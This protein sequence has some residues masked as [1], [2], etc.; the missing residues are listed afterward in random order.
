MRSLQKILSFASA[1]LLMIGTASAQS[2][3]KREIIADGKV[4]IEVIAEG[5]GPLGCHRRLDAKTPMII[6]GIGIR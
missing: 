4:R 1:L 3:R 2:D 5:A 6:N